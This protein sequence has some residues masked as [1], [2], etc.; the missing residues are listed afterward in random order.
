MKKKDLRTLQRFLEVEC[1]KR[2]SIRDLDR[3]LLAVSDACKQ[4]N[5]IVQRAQ[6]DDLY[7]A[8]VDPLTGTYV[9]NLFVLHWDYNTIQ[10]NTILLHLMM[11]QPR[12]LGDGETFLFV[13]I[14]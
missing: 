10:Y 2:S 6:T 13:S 5:R 9:C 3:T 11:I 7:G 4:I 14:F 1:W 12:A 8:A